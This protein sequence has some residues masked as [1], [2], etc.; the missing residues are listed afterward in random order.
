MI[1]LT[2]VVMIVVYILVAALV[3]G[4]LFYLVLYCEKEFPQMPLFFKIARI[5]L[6]FL[7]VLVIIGIVISI[8]GGTPLFKNDLYWHAHPD[9]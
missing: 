4:L 1:S 7:A 5:A 6:V 9:R 8:A 2:A 3:F